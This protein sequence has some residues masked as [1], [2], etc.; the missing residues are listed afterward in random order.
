MCTIGNEPTCAY[1]LSPLKV[2]LYRIS[3]SVVYLW[4]HNYGLDFGILALI[5]YDYLVNVL[6]HKITLKVPLDLD[7]GP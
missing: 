5:H 7:V 1:A 3:S 6:P 4:R 2:Y